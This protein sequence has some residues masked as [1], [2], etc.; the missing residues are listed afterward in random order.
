[1]GLFD[2]LFDTDEK[3][4]AILVSLFHDYTEEAI[5]LRAMV[6][7]MRNAIRKLGKDY[8]TVD[9]FDRGIELISEEINGDYTKMEILQAEGKTEE[10]IMAIIGTIREVEYD[11]EKILRG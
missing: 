10:E 8:V 9:M 5:E 4:K 6:A 7:G 1:M 3:A 2:Y 11:W